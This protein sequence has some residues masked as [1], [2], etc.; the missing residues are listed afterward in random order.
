MGAVIIVGHTL[1]DG[2]EMVVGETFLLGDVGDD[3]LAEAVHAH[4]EPEAENLLHF[5]A[6]EGIVH[7]EVGLL[8]RKEVEII[9]PA[10]LIPCPCLTLKVGIP[11]VGQL[12]V[13]LG[14]PPDV[15]VGVG[16][17]ALTAL[18]E[19]L[20][21]VAGVV[22]HQIHDELHAPLMDTLEDL[23]EG[24]H[25]AELRRD[26]HIVCNVIAAVRTG[27]GIDG[28]E[29]DAVAAET[30]DIVQL[31]QHAPEIAHAVAV[32]VLEAAGPDLIEYHVLIPAV[33]CH[34][35]IPPLHV[36]SIIP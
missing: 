10:L 19:P 20:V 17:D 31:L 27:R 36:F 24:F 11:V 34:T 2:E 14:I 29:P 6:D 15:I 30:L 3:V 23:A 16:L 18:L 7:V 1:V 4:V 13:R 12:A 26:V 22:Y 32:A 8:H 33:S 21:F 35:V 5:L 25:A 28:G 9:L